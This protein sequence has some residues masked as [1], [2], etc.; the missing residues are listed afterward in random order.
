MHMYNAV[1]MLANSMSSTPFCISGVA[2]L[3]AAAAAVLP[4]FD[5][6]DAVMLRAARLD[7]SCSSLSL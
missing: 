1:C 6:C 5:R 3:V 2:S 7:E 4:V